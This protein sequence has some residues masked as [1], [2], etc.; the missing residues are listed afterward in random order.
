MQTDYRGV[1]ADFAALALTAETE[2]ER[3]SWIVEI[4]SE[5]LTETQ[6]RY[7][8]SLASLTDGEVIEMLQDI[9]NYKA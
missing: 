8:D 9:A 2:S 6:Q 5:G 7:M 4:P 1:A 3:A